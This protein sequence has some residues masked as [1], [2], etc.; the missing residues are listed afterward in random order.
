MAARGGTPL[1]F[2]GI[3]AKL[4]DE[5]VRSLSVLDKIP[6]DFYFPDDDSVESVEGFRHIDS[7]PGPDR[8]LLE[9][10]RLRDRIISTPIGSAY[11]L[12]LVDKL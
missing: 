12:T 10:R 7:D 1:V 6:D 5:A 11:K 2:V 4:L 8:N 9:L 3:A